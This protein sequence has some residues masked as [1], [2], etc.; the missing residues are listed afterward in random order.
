MLLQNLTIKC[1]LNC[2]LVVNLMWYMIVNLS[3]GLSC[4][5]GSKL[6]EIHTQLYDVAL[7]VA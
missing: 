4:E 6:I 2:Y 3:I 5:V 7:S 1:I